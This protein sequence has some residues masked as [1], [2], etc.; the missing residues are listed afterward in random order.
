MKKN[1]FYSL[2]AF[3][4]V[5]ACLIYVLYRQNY[6]DTKLIPIHGTAPAALDQLIVRSSSLKKSSDR[7]D[8]GMANPGAPVTSAKT[9]L[10]LKEISEIRMEMK[11]SLASIYAAEKAFFA[12]YGRYST[13]LAAI[14]WQ[15]DNSTL[16]ARV[17]FLR[18]FYPSK[19]NESSE[20]FDRLSSNELLEHLNTTRTEQ[21]GY[22]PTALPI[23]FGDSLQKFCDSDCTA[24]DAKFE[25]IA[26]ADFGSGMEVWRINEKKQLLQV[27]D[28]VHSQH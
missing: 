11:I 22:G 16:R 17:G 18:A 8:P 24:S 20:N 1:R 5:W 23:E 4:A 27:S 12:E 26:A 14:G 10:T 6:S 19:T 7:D 13:D 25:V 15:P 28:G 3:A 9:E 2:F 21:F